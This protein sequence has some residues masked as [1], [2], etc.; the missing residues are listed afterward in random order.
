[1]KNT[2]ISSPS[3][4]GQAIRIART[5]RQLTQQEV[6]AKVGVDQSTISSVENGNAGTRLDTLFHLLAALDLEI[7]LQSRK[8]PSNPTNKEGW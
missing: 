2:S 1:M 5:N 8:A 3:A 7:T 6:G 4:L